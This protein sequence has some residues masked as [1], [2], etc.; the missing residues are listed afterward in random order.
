LGYSLRSGKPKVG[1]DLLSFT[2]VALERFAKDI[3]PFLKPTLINLDTSL[4]HLWGA[5]RVLVPP[6]RL[7]LQAS[8]ALERRR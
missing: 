6:Q 7:A 8:H 5:C 3:E 2:K 1:A 4:H